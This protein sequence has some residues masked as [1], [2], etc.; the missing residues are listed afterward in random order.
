MQKKT[1]NI[2]VSM[3]ENPSDASGHGKGKSFFVVLNIWYKSYWGWPEETAKLDPS[4]W[5]GFAF[6]GPPFCMYL[7]ERI[8]K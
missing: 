7:G 4:I 3:N 2:I 5:T 1:E 6:P 8:T